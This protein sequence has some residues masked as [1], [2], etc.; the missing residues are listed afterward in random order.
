VNAAQP[1]GR[2]L[3]LLVRDI[4][5]VG[6]AGGEVGQRVGVIDIV[7]DRQAA[8]IGGVVEDLEAGHVL[9]GHLVGIVGNGG[10]AEVERQEEQICRPVQH[11]LAHEIGV[12]R[13]IGR[14]EGGPRAR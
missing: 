2:G 12:Q 13:V 14:D 5:P 3:E 9:G 1:L 11:V 4:R 10:G 8:R 6:H 7:G